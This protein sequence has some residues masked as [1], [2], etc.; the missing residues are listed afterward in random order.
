M[1][2]T[3][4]GLPIRNGHKRFGERKAVRRCEECADVVKAKLCAARFCSAAPR[5]WS[6]FEEKHDRNLQRTGR[7][8]Q[9][10]RADSV[11]A[12]LVFLNLLECNPE[13]VAELGLTHPKHHA[14]HAQPAADM[15]VGG[16]GRLLGHDI[17]RVNILGKPQ[18][19]DFEK[20]ASAT[21][22]GRRH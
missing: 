19:M 8:L 3:P 21:L 2:N 18:R 16:I 10:T 14:A 17:A 15:P 11:R 13:N 6:A 22:S 4:P 5:A 9:A 1:D 20:L 7:M 12:V